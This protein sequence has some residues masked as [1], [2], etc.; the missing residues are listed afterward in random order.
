MEHRLASGMEIRHDFLVQL[1]YGLINIRDETVFDPTI[2]PFEI[3]SNC[4]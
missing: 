4:G 1:Y 2:T 3:Q